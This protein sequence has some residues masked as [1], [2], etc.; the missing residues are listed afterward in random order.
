MTS[1]AERDHG[2]TC[3]GNSLTRLLAKMFAQGTDCRGTLGRSA[4]KENPVLSSFLD[5]TKMPPKC[6]NVARALQRARGLH[7]ELSTMESRSALRYERDP[8]NDTGAR[9][10]VGSQSYG[11]PQ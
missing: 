1:A 8:P 2:G 10:H 4:E 7:R 5:L 6:R 11:P 3:A 9:V